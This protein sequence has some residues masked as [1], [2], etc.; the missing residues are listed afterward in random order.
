MFVYQE[1]DDMYMEVT[2]NIAL[3]TLLR[4]IQYNTIQYNTIQYNTIQYN[5]IQYNTIL[6]SLTTILKCL[7]AINLKSMTFVII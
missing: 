3:R 5:T 2:Q 6:P 1:M 4:T 7:K